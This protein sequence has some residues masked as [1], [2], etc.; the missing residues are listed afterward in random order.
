MPQGNAPFMAADNAEA[1]AARQ[2]GS[3]FVLSGAFPACR[4]LPGGTTVA[5]APHIAEKFS[6]GPL[7]LCP[8]GRGV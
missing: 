5:T 2:A 7:S 4:L 1:R 8:T 3:T 6:T